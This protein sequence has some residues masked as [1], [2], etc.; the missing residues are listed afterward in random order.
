MNYKECFAYGT[1][2]LNRAGV[3]D[4]MIDARMLLEFVCHTTRH[5]MILHGDKP[6][7]AQQKQDYQ[8]AILKRSKRIPLQHITNEQN[9]MGFDFYVNE[10]VLIPRQD[11]EVLVETVLEYMKP[12]S[13]LLDMCTGSGCILLSLLA[14]GKSCHGVG[15]DIS[16]ASLQVAKI[17]QEKIAAQCGH[18]L[19]AEWTASDLFQKIEPKNQFDVIISNP[20]YIAS[21]VIDSLEPEVKLHEPLRALDGTEN[22]LYFYEKIVAQSRSFLKDKAGLFFEIGYDQGEAVADLMRKAGFEGVTVRQ[23]YAGLD[24]VVYGFLK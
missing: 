15:A 5:D 21:A 9:F 16:E 2:I 3:P 19:Q 14:L 22:G 12:E 7:T 17:N 11:T 13:S 20:P 1:E 4:A 23:D 6:V 18:T 10:Q 8:D 24:R